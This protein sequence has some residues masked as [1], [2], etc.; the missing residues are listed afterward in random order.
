MVQRIIEIVLQLTSIGLVI[1]AA[2]LWAGAGV[3]ARPRHRDEQTFVGGTIWSQIII[4]I[5]LMI[6]KIVEEEIDIYVQ[7]YY[8]LTGI[9]LLWLTGGFLIAHELKCF[10]EWSRHDSLTEGNLSRSSRHLSRS[11]RNL[12][13]SA[14][15]IS[16][17]IL[18]E[19]FDRVYYAIGII[20]VVAGAVKLCEIIFAIIRS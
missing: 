9:L 1:A 18:I 19:Q 8:V 16:S 6:S 12:S 10:G 3:D 17:H 20:F 5:G 15:V 7:G 2:G 14:R 11:S 4:P 13:H